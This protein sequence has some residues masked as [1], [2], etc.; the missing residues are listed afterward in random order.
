MFTFCKT[1][2]Q[3][4]NFPQTAS[5]RSSKKKRFVFPTEKT[6]FPVK[7]TSL[8]SPKSPITAKG[9]ARLWNT[10]P[11][12]V[13]RLTAL[14]PF[15]AALGEF[16]KTFPDNPPVQGYTTANTNSVIDWVNQSGG[17]RLM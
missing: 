7:V 11:A 1:S 3:P 16:L 4:Y 10:L 15:K 17:M 5:K 14:D 13:T 12:H 2:Y 8:I 9:P 6:S